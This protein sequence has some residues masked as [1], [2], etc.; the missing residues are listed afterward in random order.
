MTK[1]FDETATQPLVHETLYSLPPRALVFFSVHTKLGHYVRE[2][3]NAERLASALDWQGL[4]DLAA[5]VRNGRTLTANDL[6]RVEYRQLLDLEPDQHVPS[7]DLIQVESNAAMGYFLIK[8]L[9]RLE[10]S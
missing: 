9:M 4:T 7:Y 8:L 2:N 1:A 5:Q 6:R 10:N 3:V